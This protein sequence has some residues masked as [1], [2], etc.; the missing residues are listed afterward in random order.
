[1]IAMIP[2]K[3]DE[4]IESR[5]PNPDTEIGPRIITTTPPPKSIKSHIAINNP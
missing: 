2:L 3:T 1:M 4:I 5:S